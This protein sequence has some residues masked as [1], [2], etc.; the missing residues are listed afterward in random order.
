MRAT[1]YLTLEPQY[2]PHYTFVW[3]CMCTIYVTK[4]TVKYLDGWV[5]YY[6]ISFVEIV[7][8]VLGYVTEAS[9]EL[10]ILILKC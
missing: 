4:S 6:C 9:F 7:S 5:F 10:L 8:R 2:K 3:A 1:F